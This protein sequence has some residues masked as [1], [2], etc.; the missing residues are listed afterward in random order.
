MNSQHKN[1]IEKETR[2]RKRILTRKGHICAQCQSQDQSIS[3]SQVDHL[4]SYPQNQSL[5]KSILIE[6]EG[7]NENREEIMKRISGLIL[8]LDFFVC[9]Q[10]SNGRKIRGVVGKLVN[11]EKDGLKIE[12]F[13]FAKPLK[14]RI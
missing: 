8:N 5:Q 3:T 12:T 10:F 11:K 4:L 6:L 13:G 1:I 2:K 7:Q 9:S 14:K